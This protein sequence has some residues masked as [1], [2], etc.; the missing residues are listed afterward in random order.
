MAEYV[1]N[2]NIEMSYFQLLKTWKK[3]NLILSI[4]LNKDIEISFIFCYIL[5]LN[6]Q[7]CLTFNFFSISVEQA[8]ETSHFALYFNQGQCCCAGSRT[9]VEEKIYD[10]FVERS[11]E[12]AKKR[13]VGNPFDLTNEQGPQVGTCKMLSLLC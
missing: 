12:R 6:T 3:S 4:S 10:E 8:V 2:W 9:F 7:K 1:F 5:W 13:T 11:A